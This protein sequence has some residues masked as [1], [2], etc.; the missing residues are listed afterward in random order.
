MN[1]T[2]RTFLRYAV[3]EALNAQA[4]SAAMELLALLNGTPL[5]ATTNAARAALPM[6]REITD[7]PARDYHYWTRFIRENFIPFMTGNGRLRFTS[8]ELLT[9][10]ENCSSLS[11]TT[12]DVDAHSTGRETWRNAV[13]NALSSLK[14]QGALTAAPFGKEYVISTHQPLVSGTQSQ[15]LIAGI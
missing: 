5:Q 2:A 8:H 11:L 14:Q 7:G 9:W 13:G 10:L 15:H 3:L 6:A 1:D 12:G 4:D